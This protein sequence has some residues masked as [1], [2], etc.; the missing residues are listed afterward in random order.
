MT[1]FITHHV[2]D[3][4]SVLGGGPLGG[5]FGGAQLTE[6]DVT[7]TDPP[8]S[9]KVHENLCSGSLVGKKSVPKY[10]LEYQH[11]LNYTFIKDLV[12]ITRRWVLCFT[13]VEGFGLI[14]T[15]SPNSYVRGGIWYKSNAMGQLTK[16][17]PATAYEG[18]AM[19]HGEFAKKR[20]NGKGSYGI[21][22]CN[23]TRGKA[24]RHP[25]EKPL[26]LALKLVALCSERGETVFDP[27]MGAGTIGKACM[28]LGRNYIGLDNDYKWVA[29]A[30]ARIG[31]AEDD[32]GK[33]PDEEALVLC[34]MKGEDPPEEE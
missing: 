8:Y 34:S 14:K 16:D 17:R 11:L 28:L 21:W 32:W 12:R 23:G 25:N 7:I 13:D 33:M 19:L 10:Q 22:R 3:S 18:I 2:P 4:F 26:D 24:E 15:A 30:A 5:E 1:R 6:V 9:E 27:F 20:W 31:L 29:R